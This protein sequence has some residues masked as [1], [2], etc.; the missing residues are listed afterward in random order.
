[1]SE[2]KDFKWMKKSELSSLDWAE[3]DLPILKEF[4]SL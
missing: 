4:L 1:L 2:H 3:A